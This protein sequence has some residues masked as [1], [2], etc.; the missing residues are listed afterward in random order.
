MLAE[1]KASSTPATWLYLRP[2]DCGRAPVPQLLPP[3]DATSS[4][5]SWAFFLL[6]THLFPH[7]L[8]CT[9]WRETGTAPF[10]CQD[11]ACR[12]TPLQ[13][14]CTPAGYLQD[15]FFSVASLF[16]RPFHLPL[17]HPL[18]HLQHSPSPSVRHKVRHASPL[19]VFLI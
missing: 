19:V 4:D 5:P 12:L 17:F 15:W 10:P 14:S 16:F 6:Y 9:P 2:T 18:H 1:A 7:L 11:Q 3:P 13:V 8:S